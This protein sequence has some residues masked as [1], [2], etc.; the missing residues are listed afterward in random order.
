MLRTQHMTTIK[1]QPQRTCVACREVRPKS[2]LIR[3]VRM[4]SGGIALDETGKKSG[5]GAYLCATRTCWETALT[6]KRLEHALRT[7]LGAEE[8]ETLWQHGHSLPTTLA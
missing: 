5:R 3:I 8:K 6:R 1:R 7:E 4:P 2:E